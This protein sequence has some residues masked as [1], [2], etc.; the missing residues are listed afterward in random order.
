MAME[1]EEPSASFC[2]TKLQIYV[3]ALMS[4]RCKGMNELERRK[5]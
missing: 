5:K 1:V 2:S 3:V 4:L